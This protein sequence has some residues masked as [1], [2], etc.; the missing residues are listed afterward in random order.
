MDT[1]ESV[2]LTTGAAWASGIN[3]YATLLVL[4]YLASS[5]QIVLPP[6]LEA[7][8]DP[9]F[10]TVAAI[11]YVIEFFADKAPG[12]DT[13]W[14]ALHTFIRIPAG[15]VLAMGAMGDNSQAAYLAAA[16][17]GGAL[18]ANS[19]A[20]KAGGRIL[21]N[22]SPEP[23]SNWTVSIGEDIAVLSGLYT[24]LHYPW[25]FLTGLALFILFSLWIIPRVGKGIQRIARTI[26]SFF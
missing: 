2:T 16:L 11:L 5:G 18:A 4:G 12:I 14:D 3:L 26:R 13:G 17:A 1:L 25:F 23:L 24:A 9:K 21:I 10:M 22:T 20:I 19:H 15:A 7:V 8:A 6:G